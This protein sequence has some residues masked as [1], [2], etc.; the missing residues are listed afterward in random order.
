MKLI[1]V[2]NDNRARNL[3]GMIV[4]QH[5]ICAVLERKPVRKTLQRFS[6]HDHHLAG[7]RLAEKLLIRRN[8]HQ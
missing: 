2:M 6:S 4:C 5:D 3:I 1:H 8:S 7:R